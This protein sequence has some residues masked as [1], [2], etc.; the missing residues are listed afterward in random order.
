MERLW[1]TFF[2]ISNGSGLMGGDGLIIG[3]W[4]PLSMIGYAIGSHF[5]LEE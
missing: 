1:R 3:T 4:L 2:S 5:G